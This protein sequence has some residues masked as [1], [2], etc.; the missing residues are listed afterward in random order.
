MHH[1]LAR[2]GCLPAWLTLGGAGLSADA[3]REL[4]RSVALGDSS[5]LRQVYDR[6]APRAFGIIL[7]I[8]RSRS[9]AEEVLQEAFLQI[10]RRAKEYDPARGGL[11]A[12]VVTVARTRAIDRLRTVSLQQRTA[13]AAGSE[14]PLKEG[15]ESP[16]DLTHQSESEG[17][18]AAA[19]GTLS[20]EQRQVIELA[21]FEGLSQSEI[22]ERTGTPL[23]TVKT[24]TRLALEKLGGVLQDR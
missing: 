22:A 13:E 14:A 19:L 17:R 16:F 8:L 21:Y 11:E 6:C 2:N 1:R 23:G 24:R 4:L 18:V 10:W 7:R 12:W 15:P 9:E 3:D 5:A 20:P